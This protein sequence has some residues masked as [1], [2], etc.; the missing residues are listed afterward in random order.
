MCHYRCQ[1]KF[2]GTNVANEVLESKEMEV[3]WTANYDVAVR[4]LLVEFVDFHNRATVLFP[5]A[6]TL[7]DQPFEEA[8]KDDI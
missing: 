3:F 7:L 4:A 5:L 6:S 2:A 8:A 1:N